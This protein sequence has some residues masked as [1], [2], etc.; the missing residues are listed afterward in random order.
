MERN[1]K[2][3]VNTIEMETKWLYDVL[4]SKN[5]PLIDEMIKNWM[6]AAKNLSTNNSVEQNQ[7]LSMLS[8]TTF[9]T[10]YK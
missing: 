6:T 5:I 2:T 4:C 3:I 1:N 10:P 9:Q 8:S 7:S